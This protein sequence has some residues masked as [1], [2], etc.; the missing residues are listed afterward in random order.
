MKRKI[1]FI[2][3]G[4]MALASLPVN[5]FA[6]SSNKVDRTLEKTDEKVVYYD[7]SQSYP[8]GAGTRSTDIQL[9][10]NMATLSVELDDEL[11][12]NETFTVTLA[13]ARW[14]FNEADYGFTDDTTNANA[15]YTAFVTAVSSGAAVEV[16]VSPLTNSRINIKATGVMPKD[17]II[18]F[19]LVVFSDNEDE[20]ITATVDATATTL[21]NSTHTFI[22][23]ADGSTTIAISGA[24]TSKT[25]T[26]FDLKLTENKYG[27]FA[28][29]T[30]AEEVRFELDKGFEWSKMGNET[31]KYNGVNTKTTIPASYVVDGN[32]KYNY[33]TEN[34]LGGYNNDIKYHLS[35]NGRVLTIYFSDDVKTTNAKA[36]LMLKGLLV[37]PTSDNEKYGQD[38]LMDVDGRNNVSDVSNVKVGRYVDWTVLTELVDETVPTLLSGRMNFTPIGSTAGV[39]VTDDDD[40]F[41]SETESINLGN[42]DDTEAWHKTATIHFE[43]QVENSWWAGRETIFTLPEDVNIIG[44]SLEEGSDVVTFATNANAKGHANF[45]EASVSDDEEEPEYKYSEDDKANTWYKIDKNVLKFSNLKVAATE[46]GSFD[47]TFFVAADVMFSGDVDVT[48][49]GSAVVDEL[50]PI[51]VAT[52]EQPYTVE[53]KVTNIEIG[54]QDYKVANIVIAETENGRFIQDETV[55]VELD[56]TNTA[57]KAGLIFRDATLEVTEGDI[58]LKDFNV[59]DGVINFTVDQE[60]DNDTPST[61]ELNNVRI[62]INRSVPETNADP[63]DVV[64]TTDNRTNSAA[65]DDTSIRYG[66]Y[67]IDYVNVITSGAGTANDTA[68]ALTVGSNTMIVNGEEVEIKEA[69]PY[70]DPK[71]NSMMVPVRFIAEAFDYKVEWF[72]DDTGYFNRTGHNGSVVIYLDSLTTVKLP[73]GANFYVS[74]SGSELPNANGAITTNVIDSATGNGRVYIPFR[75]VGLALGV[76][77][78]NIVYD[79]DTETAYYNRD[80]Q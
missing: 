65:T 51:T 34:F 1:A 50:D 6:S 9:D 11:K 78:E 18:K 33:A 62:S 17:T 76:A 20:D 22:Y 44:F 40:V 16:E 58:D 2:L 70:I 45:D 74:T 42:A 73:V 12:A 54:F 35:E 79:A 3:A 57:E 53:T 23:Q 68:V 7:E 4:V 32:T 8:T 59:N 41:T 27:S 36:G 72:G 63:F 48:I 28:A 49:G 24:D 71:T 61:I 67:A 26:L 56:V 13:N 52:F 46:K 64:I 38:I 19:P 15:W 60:S 69:T 14:A 77:N 30:D 10:N 5:V 37:V 25:Q 55:Y 39:A 43:E 66:A 31:L 47:I 80:V 21:S 29:G 75:T